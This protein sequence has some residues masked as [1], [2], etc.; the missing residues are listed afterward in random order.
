VLDLTILPKRYLDALGR[1]EIARLCGQTENVVAM[2]IKRGKFPIDALQRLLVHDPS[3][4]HEIQ[5]LYTV[6]PLNKKLAILMPLS[7]PPNPHV[8]DCFALLYDKREMGYQRRSFNCLSVARNSLA[9]WALRQPSLEWFFWLDG[10]D[11]IVPAGDPLWYKQAADMPN[12]SDVY[13]GINT[14]YRLLSH[15]LKR[16]IKDATFV[17]CSYVS[18]KDRGDPQFGGGPQMRQLVRQGPQDRLIEVPWVGFGGVLTH[19]SVFEDIIRT[20]GDE[21]KMEPNSVGSRFGYQ[22]GFFS[23]LDRHTPGDDVPFAERARKAGHKIYVDLAVQAGH[24]GDRVF[25][26]N[27]L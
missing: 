5:P 22:W 26:F 10:G 7:T 27:N 4:L 8:L 12:V 19:R 13:A 21:I 9:A 15:R 3:P 20:Q 14:I 17:S 25:T 6:E 24:F 11:T 2:W 16:G 1:A 23:P 18:K